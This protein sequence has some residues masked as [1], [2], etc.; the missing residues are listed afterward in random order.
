MT[1][2]KF[3]KISRRG[4]WGISPKWGVWGGTPQKNFLGKLPRKT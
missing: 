3:K 4:V 2:Y 1:P